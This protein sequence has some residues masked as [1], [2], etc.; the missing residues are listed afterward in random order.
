MMVMR[1]QSVT[2]NR[3]ARL[4]L[5]MS[6]FSEFCGLKIENLTR[7]RPYLIWLPGGPSLVLVT[8]RGDLSYLMIGRGI[9]SDGGACKHGATSARL[10][11]KPASASYKHDVGA[12]IRQSRTMRGTYKFPSQHLWPGPTELSSL[13][14]LPQA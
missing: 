10:R 3:T 5:Q 6:K 9:L 7:C 2:E 11:P 13:C 4:T 14:R 8:E 12:M 1:S